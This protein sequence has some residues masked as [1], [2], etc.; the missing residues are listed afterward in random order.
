MKYIKLYNPISN[1]DP[2]NDMI[3]FDPFF[4]TQSMPANI[5][6]DE[7]NVYVEISLPGFKKENIKINISGN[8]LFITAES[9]KE[10]SEKKGKYHK[11]EFSYKSITR[12]FDLPETVSQNDV[13]ATFEN[14]IL[15]VKLKKQTSAISKEVVIE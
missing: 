1:I 2:I 15:N 5:W 3:G 13:T 4:N 7:T 12:N 8:K 6:E 10:D 14:G 9:S 11:H